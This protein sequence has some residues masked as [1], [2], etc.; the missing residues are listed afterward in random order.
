MRTFETRRFDL[1][2]GTQNYT[3]ISSKKPTVLK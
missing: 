2:N 1:S 3:K